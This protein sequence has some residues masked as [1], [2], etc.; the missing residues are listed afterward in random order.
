M[1][2]LTC[3]HCHNRVFFENLSCETCGSTLGYAPDEQL[4]IAFGIP[5]EGSWRRLG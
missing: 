2:Q 4:M 3:S 1:K 5:A